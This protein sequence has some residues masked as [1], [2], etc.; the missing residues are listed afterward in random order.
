MWQRIQTL[1]LLLAGVI[2]TLLLI[3]PL[4]VSSEGVRFISYGFISGAE[5]HVT[6]VLYA[7]DALITF[8]CFFTIFLFKK[9]KL[10]M[11]FCVFTLLLILGYLVYAIALL[12]QYGKTIMP[13]NTDRM[14]PSVWLFLPLLAI[15][16][17]ILAFRGIRKDEIL[18]RMSN[19]LR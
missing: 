16:F 11:R 6:W 17:L 10:Q 2:M 3:L 14:T 12:M 7:L 1:W 8:L 18:I 4:G 9:R 15:L 13:M 19:R 5:Q